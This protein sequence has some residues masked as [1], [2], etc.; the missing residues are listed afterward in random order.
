MRHK[1]DNTGVGLLVLVLSYEL[2]RFLAEYDNLLQRLGSGSL[3]T[4]RQ[5]SRFIRQV[6][7][8]RRAPQR[9]GCLIQQAS[10]FAG[11]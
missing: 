5:A 3:F 7:R 11:V 8:R 9:Q 2:Y 4:L 10:A 6:Q 1:G